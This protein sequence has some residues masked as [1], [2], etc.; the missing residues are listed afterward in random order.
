M[1]GT[2]SGPFASLDGG[3][4]GM[5]VTLN[6]APGPGR[7]PFVK[8][9]NAV[10]AGVHNADMRISRTFPIHEKLN[11]Q[12]FGEVFNLANHREIASVSGIAYQYVNPAATGTCSS[13]VHSNVCIAPYTST[14]FGTPTAT[15][16]VLY[17]ARQLQVAAKLFF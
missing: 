6:N 13:A 15:S 9:N 1:S 12:V 11:F 17:G 4:T 8:R 2:L 10:Y 14:P 5:A 3:A 16:G 7:A